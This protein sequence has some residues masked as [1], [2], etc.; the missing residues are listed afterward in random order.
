MP[1]P[2]TRADT[3]DA[4]LF[5]HPCVRRVHGAAAFHWKPHTEYGV[6]PNDAGERVLARNLMPALADALMPF[7]RIP[8]SKALKSRTSSFQGP[9]RS[10]NVDTTIRTG[11]RTAVLLRTSSNVAFSKAGRCSSAASGRRFTPKHDTEC[12]CNLCEQDRRLRTV[13]QIVRAKEEQIKIGAWARIH[14]R[15]QRRCG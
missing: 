8:E 6:H 2:G 9:L 13:R 1:N 14:R 3:A 11:H 5:Q 4:V 10:R 12:L 7:T 15:C